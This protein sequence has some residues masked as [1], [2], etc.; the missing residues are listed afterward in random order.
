[1]NAV[2]LPLSFFTL[3][4]VHLVAASVSTYLHLILF[5]TVLFVICCGLY[6]FQCPHVT[7]SSATVKHFNKSTQLLGNTHIH[8]A[9]SSSFHF[10]CYESQNLFEEA[11][12]CDIS[13]TPSAWELYKTTLP[14]TETEKGYCIV[15]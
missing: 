3:Y 4:F 6:S 13:R 2:F 5:V 1:M 14:S 9:T 7:G 10:R 15:V 12:C 11:R 8:T